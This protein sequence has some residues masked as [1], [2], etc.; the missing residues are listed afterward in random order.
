MARANKKTN[1]SYEPE[2]DVL[3]WEVSDAPIDY[4]QEAGNVIVH[5]SKNNVPVYIELLEASK[6]F[7]ET[8]KL[9]ATRKSSMVGMRV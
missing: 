4:A 3:S 2:A 5:F 7:T 1:V 9:M 8:R 6:F